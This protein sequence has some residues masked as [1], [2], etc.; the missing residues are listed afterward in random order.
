MKW[1]G[2]GAATSSAA[3]RRPA[4]FRSWN[5]NKPAILDHVEAVKAFHV[6][7]QAG[8]RASIRLVDALRAGNCVC[9]HVALRTCVRS[10]LAWSE[11]AD[12]AGSDVTDFLDRATGEREFEVAGSRHFSAHAAS[13]NVAWKLVFSLTTEIYGHFYG[14]ESRPEIEPLDLLPSEGEMHMLSEM[15]E[16]EG[17][18]LIAGAVSAQ[19]IRDAIQPHKLTAAPPVARPDGPDAD[20]SVLWLDGKPYKMGSQTMKLLRLIWNIPARMI[21]IHRSGSAFRGGKAPERG[22]AAQ[23]ATRATEELSPHGF[24]LCVTDQCFELRDDRPNRK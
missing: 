2:G 21:P 9:D 18:E 17:A 7:I 20:V 5:M 24:M 16:I 15:L 1:P 19:L 12:G 8:H 4:R 22:A 14:L 6:I 10:L 13:I 11:F 3:R 23:A